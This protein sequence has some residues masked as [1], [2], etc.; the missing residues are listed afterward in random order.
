MQHIIQN[1]TIM[2][3]HSSF[4]LDLNFSTIYYSH[5]MTFLVNGYVL[6]KFVDII[7]NV[8]WGPNVYNPQICI[9]SG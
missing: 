6:C 7:T 4:M 8:V 9:T 1:N 2:Q 5:F 3:H